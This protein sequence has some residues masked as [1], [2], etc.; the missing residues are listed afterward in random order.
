M[1]ADAGD[2][3]VRLTEGEVSTVA[4]SVYAVLGTHRIQPHGDLLAVGIKHAVERILSARLAEVTAERDRVLD[5]LDRVLRERT[6]ERA[7][8][9]EARLSEG[10]VEWG[11]RGGPSGIGSGIQAGCIDPGG[12]SRYYDEELARYD[13]RGRPQDLFKRTRY[14]PAPSPWVEVSEP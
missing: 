14:S 11:V 4:S 12:T 1:S 9:A 13:T 7:E 2:E 10:V 5:E 8:A 6:R 3:G